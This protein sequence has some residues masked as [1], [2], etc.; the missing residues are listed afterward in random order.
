MISTSSKPYRI[1]F[2]KIDGFIGDYDGTRYLA[3]FSPEKYYVI[4]NRIR[5]LTS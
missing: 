2:D 1:R 3:L 4:Y 5:Y